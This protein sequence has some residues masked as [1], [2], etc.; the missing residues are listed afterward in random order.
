[1]TRKSFHGVCS[2]CNCEP[3]QCNKWSGVN[4]CQSFTKIPQYLGSDDSYHTRGLHCT[5]HECTDDFNN[6]SFD[7]D[8]LRLRVLFTFRRVTLTAGNR[9]TNSVS[10]KYLE[11]SSEHAPSGLHTAA[12]LTVRY[13]FPDLVV[14]RVT[15]FDLYV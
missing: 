14:W 2:R 10:G 13:R 6:K 15:S 8:L 11:L 4:V 12:P 7:P 5:S 3:S 9:F 1:M